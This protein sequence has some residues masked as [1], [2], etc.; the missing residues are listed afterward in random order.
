MSEQK[1]QVDNILS[2]LKNNRIVA[3]I[4]VFGMAI[5]AISSFTD[6]SHKIIKQIQGF[7]SD[8]PVFVTLRHKPEIL[9][10]DA[11][12]ILLA[13]HGFYE[14]KSNPGGKGIANRYEFQIKDNAI[15]LL[16]STT[17]LM[18]Q[19]GGSSSQMTYENT[20]QYV[21]RINAEKFA[22]FNDWR[23][24]TVE[25]AMSLMEA[26]ASDHIHIDPKFDRGINSIW[27]SDRAANGRIWMLNFYDGIL[28][29]ESDSFN[30][31]VRLVR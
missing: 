7:F 21:H 1:T 17:G 30:T 12:K 14:R 13:K 26:Q 31:W 22:G 24:P 29:S 28:Y 2:R 27:T 10:N 25:E 4:I 20:K 9:S 11:V 23:L 8:S 16:D 19:K 6:A 5:I 18:W 3:I 15:I